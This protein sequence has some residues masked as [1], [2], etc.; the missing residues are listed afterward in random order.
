M[1]SF[2]DYAGSSVEAPATDPHDRSFWSTESATEWQRLFRHTQTLRW[3]QGEAIV[4]AGHPNLSIFIIT[5]G[6]VVRA[7]DQDTGWSEGQVVGIQSFF[8]GQVATHQLLA[9]TDVE[10]VRLTRDELDSIAAR[11]PELAHRIT[12]ELGRLLALA[13]TR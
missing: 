1:S 2:F 3:R 6:R 8:S 12:L 7:D 11:E 9:A 10:A 13:T 5:Q 4:A